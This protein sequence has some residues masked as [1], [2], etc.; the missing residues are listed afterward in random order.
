[1]INR[2]HIMVVCAVL[3]ASGC[4][5]AIDCLD[6]DG[7]EFVTGAIADPVLNQVC[8]LYTSDAADE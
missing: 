5:S 6:N 3:M 8:L 4:E 7:P 1:M 2:T